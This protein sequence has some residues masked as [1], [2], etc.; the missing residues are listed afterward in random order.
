M[1]WFHLLHINN[2][3]YHEQLHTN[4]DI[5]NYIC[6]FNETAD[7]LVQ[8]VTYELGSLALLIN[9][10]IRRATLILESD[11]V[12]TISKLSPNKYLITWYCSPDLYTLYIKKLKEQ[13]CGWKVFVFV[14]V[15][16]WI[17]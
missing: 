13:N 12:Y 6:S 5:I 7:S 8:C 14:Y 1:D 17:Y 4:Y 2:S 10:Q 3:L 9:K 15:F 16:A 11:I